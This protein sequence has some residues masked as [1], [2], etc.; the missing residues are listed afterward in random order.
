[1]L[2]SRIDNQKYD[3]TTKHTKDT[4]DP[5]I[6]MFRFVLVLFAGY[7]VVISGFFSCGVAALGSLKVFAARASFPGDYHGSAFDDFLT[8]KVGRTR[9]RNNGE[10]VSNLKKCFSFVLL[11]CFVVV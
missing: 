9:R 6:I 4:K 5:E 7:F 3:S 10:R 11:V 1:M 2:S 8:T